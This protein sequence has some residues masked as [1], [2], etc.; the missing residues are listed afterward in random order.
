V[1]PFAA[2]LNLA[3]G[4]LIGPVLTALGHRMTGE[5]KG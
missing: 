5:Q 2:A 1:I 3:G 4:L